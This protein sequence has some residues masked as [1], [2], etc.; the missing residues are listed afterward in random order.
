MNSLCALIATLGLTVA[1]PV[2]AP[3]SPAPTKALA[4][5]MCKQIYGVL[6]VLSDGSVALYTDPKDPDYLGALSRLEP[7]DF[8]I[9]EIHPDNGCPVIT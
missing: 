9:V 1:A 7:E 4:L 3:A 6:V 8:G 2:E 5:L